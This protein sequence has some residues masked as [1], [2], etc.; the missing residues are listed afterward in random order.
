M[1]KVRPIRSD[2]F[3]Q[4]ALA[5]S[6]A[7]LVFAVVVYRFIISPA[8]DRL[9]EHEL[10]INSEGIR[11]T[12]QDYFGEI[13]NNLDLLSEYASQG[14]FVSDEPED[15]QRFAAP[16]MKHNQSYYA[17]RIAREDSREVALFKNSDGWSTRFTYPLIA[18]GIEQWSH[19]DKNNL[20]LRKETIHNGY[21]CRTQP[22]FIGALQ[23]QGSN[24]AYW[25]SP[26]QFLSN[27]ES[28]ISASV[29]F[30]AN[31]GV[32]YVLSMDTSV[33]NIS[34][35]TRYITVGTGGFIAL[36]DAAGVIVGQPPRH[37]WDQQAPFSGKIIKTVYDIPI[38]A[39][40][41]EQWGA[42]GQ[43]VN[44]NLFYQVGSVD[45]I[46]RFIN[47]SLG[48]HTYYIGMFVPADDFR[49]NVTVPLGILGFGLLL[50]LV[51]SFL[52]TRQITAKISH[53]LQQLVAGSEQI[54]EL[55]FTPLEF[56]PTHWQ[57]INELALAHETMRR[58][59]AEA[60][61]DLETRINART[62]ALQKFS[63][64]I[65]QSPVSVMI[66]DVEGNIEYVNPKF[67]QL[68]G[69]TDAEVIGQNPRFLKSG[70]TNAET[71]DEL[72]QTL[73]AGHSWQGE[74]IN[75]RKD[76]G[77]FNEKAI[78]TPLRNLTGTITH[79]VAVKEDVTQMK[80]K[81]EELRQALQTADDATQAK[82]MFLAN[83]S[84]EIRTPMNA[85]IGMS[86]LALK[87]ELTPKQHDYVNKIHNASTSLLGIINEILDFSKIEA[88]KLQLD[89]TSFV[90][91]EVMNG[92]FNL[93]HAQANAKGL[94]FLYHIAP[95]IPQQLVGDP[96]RLAQ[97]MTNLINNAVK[98]TSSGFITIDGQII[99]RMGQKV[100]LQFA[101][102][103]TGIGMSSDQ[104]AR[105]FQAFTQADG[106]TTRKYGGTGL[107]LAISKRLIEI[108]GGTILVDSTPGVG[109]TFTFTAWFELSDINEEKRRIVPETLNKLRVLVVDDNQ[110]GR[111][112]ISEYL[113]TMKFRVDEAAD[114]QS[115]IDAVVHATDDPY[116]L[117][118]MDWQMPKMDGIE[119]ARRIKND[120]DISCIPA[121][122]IV[123][124]FDRE[125]IYAQAQQYN[126]DGLLIKPV[127]PSHLLD[128][129]LRLFAPKAAE[130]GTIKP[131]QEKNHGLSGL[132]I[133]LAEDNEINQQI[134]TEL[135]QSQGVQVT[136]ASDGREAVD[137][138]LEAEDQPGFDMI[139]MDLQM[140]TMDGFE[141]T[142][143]IRKHFDQLPIIAMT[144][145]AMADERENCLAAG[146][147]D[148][149]A[150]P[151]D[152]Q[153]LFLTIA[154]W[155]PQERTRTPWRPDVGSMS[156]TSAH[157]E[158][159]A[160]IPKN[161]GLDMKLG[162]K[163]VAGN[164]SLYR[165]L[166]RQYVSGQAGA[167]A[168]IR[169]ML[170]NGDATSGSRIAHSLK[171]VSGNIGATVI[172]DI[173]A[174]IEA[175]IRAQQQSDEILVMLDT[176]E[177]EFAALSQS[178]EE[179]LP[180][181]PVVIG[182]SQRK[183]LGVALIAE[184]Q[185][186]NAL[187]ANNDGEALDCFDRLQAEL[188]AT[189]PTNEFGELERLLSNF[190]WES[191][192]KKIT[193]LL[194]EGAVS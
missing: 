142:A 20:F 25:T 78:I 77:L 151:I 120:L 139:L 87:T 1:M 97:I 53:P 119:A 136:V 6:L 156:I 94:E 29:R 69:Y 91:D 189:L 42:G 15:F 124:S 157:S 12:V 17:F 83:M 102:S 138:V 130:P 50:A 183:T 30:S 134:A 66:T 90:L 143:A 146:M 144:A 22:G 40:V 41:Y 191:A 192:Q 4:I 133:L 14:Y 184:L 161:T 31:N 185:Q 155:A 19:W 169:E 180:G 39:A 194:K 64:A 32:R 37:V 60:A 176:L 122:V 100:E 16:L 70:H 65:E 2:L 56:T 117:V 137:R 73:C 52:W 103:D 125:E 93:T 8:A 129:A 80:K 63:R 98:F 193:A 163:R 61:T 95:D 107:G 86:Y 170:K 150:K 145:H 158:P 49:P 96:L 3:Q 181:E 108:M 172:A 75:K 92:V 106:S 11:N 109:S 10:M 88:G 179:Y 68:T 128:V 45:W 135:L 67:C 171:G 44:E 59:I 21:D 177:I 82:S 159:E 182:P 127:T 165:K 132:R 187:L 34:A 149:V 33:N 84:H 62:L 126:L 168:S 13:E 148:H 141:A 27:A 116:S 115:A 104:V 113:T 76:G 51:F 43:H 26:Y 5:F 74:F 162:L 79:Y 121:I 110:A 188:A 28:G 54:G 57:E 105:L 111:E 48:G 152:P 153:A 186:L 72:W 81:E 173:A 46:A 123:T 178:I 140:P 47:L 174:A 131:L 175:A 112:I 7:T 154:R 190:E 36:F 38:A 147:N 85:I 55:N 18:P 160:M 89:S 58:Q 71:Y 114:G 101:V 167:A 99:G 24:A 164:L 35:M 166:L 23:Q 118:L 9:A